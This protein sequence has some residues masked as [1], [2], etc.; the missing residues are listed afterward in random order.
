MRLGLLSAAAIVSFYL[1]AI[2]LASLLLYAGY[3]SIFGDWKLIP[4]AAGL[5]MF[6]GVLI[7]WSILPRRDHFEQPGPRLDRSRHPLLFEK[8]DEV[9]RRVKQSPPV[10]VYAISVVNAAV[11]QRGGIAGI[12][13]RRIMMIGLPLLYS[14][15][16]EEFQAILAHEFGHFYAGDTLFGPWVYRTRLA[17]F[18]TIQNLSIRNGWIALVRLFFVWYSKPFSRLTFWVARKQEHSAD[19]LAARTFGTETMSQALMKISVC[20]FLNSVFWEQQ[21]A[22]I[23]EE[24]Y[25]PPW[26]AGFNRYLSSEQGKSVSDALIGGA[27]VIEKQAQ[28]DTHPALRERLAAIGAKADSHCDFTMPHCG[29]LLGDPSLLESQLM[30]FV[31]PFAKTEFKTVEWDDV[32]KNVFLPRWR[33]RLSSDPTVWKAISVFSLPDHCSERELF[34]LG[35]QFHPPRRL[36]SPD[37]SIRWGQG[38]IA[39]ALAVALADQNWEI[40]AAPEV[41]AVMTRDGKTIDPFEVAAKFVDATLT[42]SDWTDQCRAMGVENLPILSGALEQE[43]RSHKTS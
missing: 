13:S 21:M 36:P 20:G 41:G 10:E 3:S 14:L 22:A 27:I 35:R 19:A 32:G 42:P 29:S 24:G 11:V 4:W 7:L 39:A 40:S 15:S 8:I 23:L 18:R 25:L 43:P 37:E 16:P 2:S 12:G 33:R 28:F 17:I 5:A 38:I 31:P 26:G 1:V 34:Q 6:A 9:A 30:H